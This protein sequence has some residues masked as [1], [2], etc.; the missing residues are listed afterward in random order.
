[1]N[2]RR[3]LSAALAL[4]LLDVALTLQDV[5][6]TPGVQWA[7]EV[8]LE[9]TVGVLV[10]ALLR[11]VLHW[12]LARLAQP[13]A[14][15]LVMLTIGRYAAIT[16]PAL[17]G[18]PINLYWDL[19]HVSN[20]IGML[21]RVAPPWAIAAVVLAMIALCAG[22]YIVM[23]WC[24]R[25][26][27]D[28]LQFPGVPVAAAVVASLVLLAYALQRPERG[29]PRVLPFAEPV[30]ATYVAQVRL[31][32]DG[33]SG[34]AAAAALPASPALQSD[35][36]A[37]AGGDVLVLFLESYGSSTYDRPGYAAALAPARA[38]LAQ[39]IRQTH[40]QVVSAF[41]ES[42]TFGG[43]SWLA[44]LSLMSGI[45]VRDPGRYALLMTQ[46]RDTLATSFRLHGYRTVAMMPGLRLAWPEGRF[47]RFDTIH[48]AASL[49]YT[50]PEF[51]WFHIPDQFSLAKL[52]Q[53]ELRPAPRA[54]VF[55]LFPTLSTHLPFRPTPPYQPNWPRML[56]TDPYDA[57]VLK[58]ALAETPS[59]LNMG[60]SYMAAVQYTLQML[61]GFLIERADPAMV[62]VLLGD[63]QPAAN[64]SG[65]N[66]SW[67][68]PVHVITANAR[69]LA[70]LRACG[71]DAGLAPR[72]R[73]LGRMDEL[74]PLLLRAFDGS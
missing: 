9:I 19:P 48:D 61:S 6:P 39:A 70:K 2:L 60:D 64:T 29:I 8:S 43:G 22:L 1:L 16:A 3:G 68:V 10:L 47:Y 17:Y 38:Q 24:V 7:G 32:A 18:R 12:P 20:V 31:I 42:P 36:G 4:L 5:W 15:L 59:W 56:G 62:L 52:E 46:Q 35:L 34:S 21:T 71:F 51:G 41:V 44:H 50:G 25:R 40:R 49:G 23:L 66:A 26:M 33:L 63:H 55:V 45:E 69:V 27:L 57:A 30:L 65:E 37:L 13:L 28:A 53:R 74:A 58:N 54:P 11:A 73:R 14:V 72:R 67:D